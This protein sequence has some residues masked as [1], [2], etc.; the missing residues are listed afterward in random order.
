MIDDYERMSLNEDEEMKTIAKILWV[1][2]GLTL[3]FWG[4][5]GFI[6]YKIIYG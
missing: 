6:L 3:L 2:C 5:I 4:L 1:G